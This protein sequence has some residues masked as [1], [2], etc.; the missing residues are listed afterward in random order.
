[1]AGLQCYFFMGIPVNPEKIKD[2][3]IKDTEYKI[4][5]S[6]LPNIYYLAKML[7]V[8]V[9]DVSISDM[10]QSMQ[11]IGNKMGNDVRQMA[12]QDTS[13]FTSNQL[14]AIIVSIT[15]SNIISPEKE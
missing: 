10:Q 9:Y 6:W 3:P 7:D 13:L 5:H 15:H 2:L 14:T 1:M 11:Q 8:P 12:Q 4:I